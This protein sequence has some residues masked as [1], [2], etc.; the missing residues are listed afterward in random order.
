[1]TWLANLKTLVRWKDWFFDKILSLFFV[2][3]YV[4]LVDSLFS[5][6]YLVQLFILLIFAILSATFGFLVNDLGDREIDRRQGK[7]NA[8]HHIDPTWSLLLLGGLL[9]AATF[10]ASLFLQQPGFLFLWGLWVLVTITYSLPP[11]RFKERGLWGIVAPGMAQFVL[12]PLLF[13]AAFG[14]LI[15]WDTGL[16]TAY[17][18]VK[19]LSIAFGQQK[20]DLDG[21]ACT[22]TITYAVQAGCER[23]ARAYSAVLLAEQVLLAL[24]L[25]LMLFR[26]PPLERPGLAGRLPPAL[27]LVLGYVFLASL[28]VRRMR[29]RG[30]ITDP[31]FDP[32]KDIFNILY[33]VFPC[34]LAP[35]YMA[36]LMSL[37]YAGNLAILLL[38][39]LWIGPSP[40]R[41]L[42]PLRAVLEG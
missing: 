36:L 2:A 28:A 29:A 40:R 27:P 7:F 17:F 32:D 22:G 42:W 33:A 1:M 5:P 8:F 9:L 11:L 4:A 16:V 41:L 38:L 21:D 6:F 30:R 20:R 18:A 35:I 24:V 14:H 37:H 12:P 25:A 3:F 31:Y 23:V 10:A 39:I 19:G 15:A 13:F 34:G 26:I